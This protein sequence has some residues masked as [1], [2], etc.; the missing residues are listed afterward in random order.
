[1]SNC[2]FCNKKLRDDNQDLRIIDIM[3]SIDVKK[4]S[5]EEIK[6]YRHLSYRYCSFNHYSKHLKFNHKLAPIPSEI[7]KQLKDMISKGDNFLYF[8]Q[9][10]TQNMIKI[11]VSRTPPVRKHQLETKLPYKLKI[12]NKFKL[13]KAYSFEKAFHNYYKK[14][15]LN[16]EWFE[17]DKNEID[18]ILNMNIKD[19]FNKYFKKNILKTFSSC[20]NNKINLNKILFYK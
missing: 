17:L 15:R 14:Q 1:M 9:L 12:L 13:K 11:G 2:L 4:L 6:G 8:F 20:E 19:M 16:G 5:L 10:G 18:Y 7:I 3:Y